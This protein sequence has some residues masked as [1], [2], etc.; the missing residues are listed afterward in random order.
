MHIDQTFYLGYI[1]KVIGHK[2]ELAF[3]LDVDSP[4]VYQGIDAVLVQ[5][6]PQDQSLVPYFITQSKLQAKDILRCKVEGIDNASDAKALVG[7]SLFLPIELLPE[8]KGD[9]FYF[10][11]VIG[12]EVIDEEK[13][14]LGKIEKVLEYPQSNLFSI[15][16]GEKE[17]LIPINDETIVEVDREKE[18][19][20][21]K[22]PEGLV[23]LYLN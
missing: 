19:I 6:M 8:L 13:G 4:S 7:K 21:V 15:T 17:I 20:K 18:L 10:H 14:S 16:K 3:K 9:Q 5:I 12:F 2:G 11:E 23:D 22:A 1:S